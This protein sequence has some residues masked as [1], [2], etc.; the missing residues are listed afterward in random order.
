MYALI[1]I[2]LVIIRVFQS[3]FEDKVESVN[4]TVPYGKLSD[5]LRTVTWI[6]SCFLV[7]SILKFF[8]PFVVFLVARDMDSI[9][10]LLLFD[11]GLFSVY[12]KLWAILLPIVLFVILPRYRKAVNELL[13]QGT[14]SDELINIK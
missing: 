3:A 14:E 10:R 13:R 7:D 11:D 9:K 6:V 5:G 12:I 1:L 2:P 4:R 8:T